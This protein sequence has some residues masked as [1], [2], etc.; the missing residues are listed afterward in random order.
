MAE[1]YSVV[2]IYRILFMLLST[3]EYLDYFH[4]LA[5]V[6]DAAVNMGM[7]ISILFFSLSLTFLD[8]CSEVGLLDHM[9][10]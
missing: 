2:C 3:D 10:V 9:I 4:I 8:K 7:Q 1:Q 6:N 5:T